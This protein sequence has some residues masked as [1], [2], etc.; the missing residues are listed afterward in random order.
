MRKC[1]N[2]VDIEEGWKRASI[3]ISGVS[4]A[5]NEPP[6]VPTLQRKFLTGDKAKF[7]LIRPPWKITGI[8]CSGQIC[9]ACRESCA[10]L[11]RSG[12]PQRGLRNSRKT[13][14][15]PMVSTRKRVTAFMAHRDTKSTSD[16]WASSSSGVRLVFCTS[17]SSVR[18]S[19]AVWDFACKLHANS[20][21][22]HVIHANSLT[23]HDVIGKLYVSKISYEFAYM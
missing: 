3:A 6:E 4:A 14:T 8:P 10:T 20:F 18:V 23:W 17:C 9:R 7:L 16:G 12:K 5:E 11:S 21:F 2:L 1:A 13:A 19:V 22:L 15:P